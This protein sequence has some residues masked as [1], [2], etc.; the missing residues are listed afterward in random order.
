MRA[1]CGGEMAV[2]NPLEEILEPMAGIFERHVLEA[3]RDALESEVV[4][5]EAFRTAG[6]APDECTFYC[7]IPNSNADYHAQLAI[8]LSKDALPAL[9]PGEADP[10][11]RLDALGRLGKMV[12]SQLTADEAFIGRFGHLKSSVPFFSEGAYT[13]RKDAGMRGKVMANGADLAFHLTVRPAGPEN[14]APG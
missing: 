4:V 14:W 2:S 11:F 6:D 7:L 12:S 3:T 10:R 9:F 13:G 8:G 1:A 5:K